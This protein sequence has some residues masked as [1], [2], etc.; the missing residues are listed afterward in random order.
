VTDLIGLGLP[1]GDLVGDRGFSYLDSCGK[2][3][4]LVS[5]EFDK[6]GPPDKLKA[7]VEQFP[8]QVREQTSVA[9]IRG[10]DHFFAGQLPELDRAIAEWLVARRPDLVA[11]ES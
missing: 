1:V 7:M 2:P 6:Y 10:G 4:L 9:I 8:P 3:K 5:G 11:S